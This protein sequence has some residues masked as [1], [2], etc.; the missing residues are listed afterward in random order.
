MRAQKSREGWASNI[1]ITLSPARFVVILS[2]IS[3][4]YGANWG[5]QR[6]E[7]LL[8]SVDFRSKSSVHS[9]ASLTLF[10][11]IFCFAKSLREPYIRGRC[12]RSRRKESPRRRKAHMRA[13]ALRQPLH[14]LRLRLLFPKNLLLRK[15]FA[16]T[17]SHSKHNKYP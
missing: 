5:S 10:P 14:F 1:Q 15:I 8:G 9:L 11:Q 6:R 16:G 4:K 13:I 12:L 3:A 7:T 2:T 17:L